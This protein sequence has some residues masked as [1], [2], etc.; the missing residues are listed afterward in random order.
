MSI[1]IKNDDYLSNRHSFGFYFF[2]LALKAAS[3]A[4]APLLAIIAAP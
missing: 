3:C 4:S 2:A 1:S